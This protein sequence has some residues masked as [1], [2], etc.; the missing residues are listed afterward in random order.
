MKEAEAPVTGKL[1]VASQTLNIY[2]RRVKEEDL[3]E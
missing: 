1:Q 2:L 3:P